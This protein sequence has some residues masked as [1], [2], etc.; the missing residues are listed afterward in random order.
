MDLR[1]IFAAHAMQGLLARGSA[2][3]IES[4][5]NIAYIVADSMMAQRF[6]AE[7]PEDED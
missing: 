2:V 7:H 4:V 3:A 1:D 6:A 5:S